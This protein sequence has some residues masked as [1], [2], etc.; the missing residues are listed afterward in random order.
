[1]S[2]DELNPAFFLSAFGQ[3]SYFDKD[4]HT[5]F[6]EHFLGEVK[7]F[8][9]RENEFICYV[10]D[11]RDTYVIVHI[12]SIMEMLEVW[13]GDNSMRFHFNGVQQEDQTRTIKCYITFTKDVLR[14][15]SVVLGTNK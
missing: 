15:L 6:R 10:N 14:S 2:R 4:I 1:M 11:D 12:S 8:D 13:K 3:T 9:K 7:S 5:I